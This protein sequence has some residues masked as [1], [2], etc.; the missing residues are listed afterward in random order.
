[1]SARDLKAVARSESKRAVIRRVWLR[2]WL[3]YAQSWPPGQAPTE[4]TIS[5]QLP[6]KMAPSTVYWHMERIREQETAR[7]PAQ[8]LES[9]QF[10]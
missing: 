5:Q 4:K 9:P 10:I 2:Q 7:E 1:M 6:F 3:T 8:A